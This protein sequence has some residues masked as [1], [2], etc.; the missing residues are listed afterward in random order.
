MNLRDKVIASVV[1]CLVVVLGGSS[2][3]NALATR[4]MARNQEASSARLVAGSIAKA[5]ETFGE[6]GDMDGLRAFMDY[7]R[8][9]DDVLEVRGVRAPDVVAEF[10]DREGAAPVD[11]IDRAA[12]SSGKAQVIVD[13]KAHTYRSVQPVIAR[14]HCISCHEEH[15]VGDVMGVA[16]V[17]LRTAA[18]DKALAG[19]TVNTAV[20]AVLAVVLAAGVLGFVINRLVIVPVRHVAGRLLDDVDGLT[21]AAGE[22]A[23]SSRRVVDGANDQA[24]SLQET[25]ASLETM[26]HRT[27]S[28]AEN[29]DQAQDRARRA[30]E[31]ARQSSS[32]VGGMVEAINA[33]KSS[34]DQTV[35]ILKTIDE[36]AFQTNLLALNAAVEAARAGDAGKGFAVVAEEVRSLAQRSAAAAQ[37]TS[38]LIESS[39]ANADH[40]VDASSQVARIIE[41]ITG[42]VEETA[43]LMA[44]VAHASTDQAEGIGQVKEAV[45]RIDQVSQSNVIMA[46]ESEQSSGNLK[47]MG[48]G[49]RAV[50][51][52]LTA[53]V[54]R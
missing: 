36:I 26:A 13:R 16:N 38:A 41:E 4:R 20:S 14:E 32:A 33:I 40:G 24:A 6:I 2:A 7:V 21:D 30:L 9:D 23:Q 48:A 46:A 1:A 10:G 17:T 15:K 37:E 25:S 31:S 8:E 3:Y 28:N 45:A 42:N 49:L 22:L 18:A 35:T 5:M 54:G 43:R 11:D 50:S 53:M 44:E 47:T 39:Q 51:E 19:M 12:L 27:R 29:A 34:S 52:R